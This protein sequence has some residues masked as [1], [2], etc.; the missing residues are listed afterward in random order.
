MKTYSSFFVLLFII[1]G[2]TKLRAQFTGGP[3]KVNMNGG[4]SHSDGYDVPGPVILITKIG[5]SKVNNQNW[6]EFLLGVGL[7]ETDNENLLAPGVGIAAGLEFRADEISPK[8]S[9]GGAA[10]FVTTSLNLNY[11]PL[12][13]QRVVFTPEI[14]INL[15][16]F[17]HFTY[18]YQFNQAPLEMNNSRI[19]PHRFSLYLTL[20]FTLGSD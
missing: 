3:I 9:I 2:T 6:G 8:I 14:G 15:A 13:Q 10:Y 18:G 4:F 20:P 17:I 1:A 11:Y 16:K 7:N 19:N 12:R 5:I